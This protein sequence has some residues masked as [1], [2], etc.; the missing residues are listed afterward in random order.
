MHCYMLRLLL[1]KLLDLLRPLGDGSGIGYLRQKLK[2]LAVVTDDLGAE[3]SLQLRAIRNKLILLN[4][5]S[6]DR[7]RFAG[8][9]QSEDP[10]IVGK[11]GKRKLPYTSTNLPASHI[12]SIAIKKRV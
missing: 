2:F 3:K 12:F 5:S 6:T 11:V 9:V 7:G 1:D 4:H 10:H 8:T